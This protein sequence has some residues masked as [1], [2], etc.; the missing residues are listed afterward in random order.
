MKGLLG[1]C[2]VVLL[3]LGGAATAS[4][5][6]ALGDDTRTGVMAAGAMVGGELDTPDNFLLFGADARWPIS[7][8]LVARGTE[9]EPRFTYH[10]L[11]G[12]HIIQLDANLL[13]NIRLANPG[14]V[15][16]L[17]GIGGAIRNE[18]YEVVGG[19]TKLGL[20]LIYGA[21]MTM[22]SARGYEPF[23]IGQY[24]II[25]DQFN[26]FSIVVGASFRLRQ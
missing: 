3:T 16:P 9:F 7:R 20:N 25:Q 17:F 21:R 1:V 12:G 26:A 14:R 19:E 2:A 13:K 8:W 6:P 11:N 4:A 23:V 22:D 10:P 15:R 18:T 5:Q 24:T